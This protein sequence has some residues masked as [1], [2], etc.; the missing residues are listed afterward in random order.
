MK[1]KGVRRVRIEILAKNKSHGNLFT[2]KFVMDLG[3]DTINSNL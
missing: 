3:R 1:V 2:F